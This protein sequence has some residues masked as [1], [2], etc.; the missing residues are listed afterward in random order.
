MSYI[1]FVV[2]G[3]LQVF[4]RLDIDNDGHLSRIEFSSYFKEDS[5]MVANIFNYLD[6]NKDLFVSYD[7][8][9]SAIDGLQIG[10]DKQDDIKSE[11][12]SP[13]EEL[14]DYLQNPGDNF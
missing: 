1:F 11:S 8:I 12:Q 9:A 10:T 6:H 13:E 5:P 7:E 4:D 14:A 3:I 2:A